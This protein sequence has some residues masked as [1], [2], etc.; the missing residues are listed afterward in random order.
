MDQSANPQPPPTPKVTTASIA[1][2]V[3]G[4]TGADGADPVPP[5]TAKR[6][7]ILF[8]DDPDNPNKSR[9]VLLHIWIELSFLHGG[10]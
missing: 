3:Y 4:D 8:D 9:S 6:V 5:S 2:A 1:A 10:R 7:R